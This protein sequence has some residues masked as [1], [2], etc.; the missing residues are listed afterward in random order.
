MLTDQPEKPR[1]VV[2]GLRSYSGSRTSFLLTA[3]A[4][5]KWSPAVKLVRESTIEIYAPE[6]SAPGYVAA[7]IL[8]QSRLSV[9]ELV[10]LGQTVEERLSDPRNPKARSTLRVDLMW[11][12]GVELKTEAL[13]LPNA[14]LFTKSWAIGTF[15]RAAEEAVPTRAESKRLLNALE[16][17]SGPH[18]IGGLPMLAPHVELTRVREPPKPPKDIWK[19]DGDDWPDG[20]AAAAF[21]LGAIAHEREAPDVFDDSINGARNAAKHVRAEGQVRLEVPIGTGASDSEVMHQ[22]LTAVSQLLR[23]SK[24]RLA[25]AVVFEAQ[26][27]RVRGAVVGERL[28]EALADVRLSAVLADR[29]PADSRVWAQLHGRSNLTHVEIEVERSL[30]EAQP[31]NGP[32]PRR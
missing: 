32:G 18:E 9:Q 3:E 26:N 4:L 17:V 19:V 1:S 23:A 15:I 31:P 30:G 5:F 13:Q 16:N 12:E 6:G 25:S 29:D 24:M 28:P 22:W 7:S 2:F 11:V 27:D 21:V 8:L 20:L 14:E 10:A